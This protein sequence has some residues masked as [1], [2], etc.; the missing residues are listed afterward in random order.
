MIAHK[1]GGGV[2]PVLEE[3]HKKSAFFF[4]E[5]PLLLCIEGGYEFVGFAYWTS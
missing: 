4:W 2:K 1:G 3:V 5:C